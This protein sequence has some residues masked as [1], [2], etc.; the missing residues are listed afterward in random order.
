MIMINQLDV[1]YR[2]GNQQ[3]F[4]KFKILYRVILGNSAS[5][6]PSLIN[7]YSKLA[8]NLQAYSIQKM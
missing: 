7:Q 1:Q 4:K 2:I 8:E 3:G 5:K 6:I